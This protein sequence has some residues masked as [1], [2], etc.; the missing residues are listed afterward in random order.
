[1]PINMRAKDDHSDGNKI[2]IVL[3]PLAPDTLAPL[4][5]LTAIKQ[6]DSKTK[7]IA[8]GYAPLSLMHFTLLYQSVG[9]VFEWL[10]LFRWSR[11]INHFLLSNLKGPESAHYIGPYKIESIHPIS[12]VPPG[13]GINITVISYAGK[14]NVGMVCCKDMAEELHPVG[15]YVVEAFESL[16]S[17]CSKINAG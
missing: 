13:G 16:E 7:K 12:I 10:R 6:S 5:R 14:M 3:L 4:Q 8:H 9:V 11:P 17:E 15:K 2:A 1:M